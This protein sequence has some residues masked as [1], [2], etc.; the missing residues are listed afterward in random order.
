MS[1]QT[2]VE[3]SSVDGKRSRLASISLHDVHDDKE[4]TEEDEE[5]EGVTF[6]VLD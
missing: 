5:H 1:F 3:M 6:R 2:S 4:S